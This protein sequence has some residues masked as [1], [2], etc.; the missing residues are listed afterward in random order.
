MSTPVVFAVSNK[1][2][3]R[4]SILDGTSLKTTDPLVVNFPYN[5]TTPF[6][7]PRWQ[8]LESTWLPN[9]QDA[10]ERV[11]D[12]KDHWDNVFEA[13]TID[14]AIYLISDA[15]KLTKKAFSSRLTAGISLHD[16]LVRIPHWVFNT[17][18]WSRMLKEEK[19]QDVSSTVHEYR[20]EIK[21]LARIAEL[22]GR[23]FL[24]KG[25]ST[26]D[27]VLVAPRARIIKAWSPI[28]KEGLP[29]IPAVS[30]KQDEYVAVLKIFD[31]CDWAIIWRYRETERC[32]I[33]GLDLL[34]CYGLFPKSLLD[35]E[36]P[37][38]IS[39]K[40]PSY[41][42]KIS[43]PFFQFN[44]CGVLTSARRRVVVANK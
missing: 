27:R 41:K 18:L 43:F 34:G 44:D 25:F 13:Q 21:S 11:P 4:E 15:L 32:T 8:R 33:L 42:L 40:D 39:F 35:I 16:R 6:W 29:Q 7:D 17:F 31:D 26:G 14:M 28:G 1:K 23:E 22:F 20:A 5:S 19:I 36:V 38:K 10:W 9:L 2:R 12:T 37:F 30:A 3:K 24:V